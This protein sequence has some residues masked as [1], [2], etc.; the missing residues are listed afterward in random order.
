[1]KNSIVLSVKELHKLYP[2]RRSIIDLLRRKPRRWVHA[3]DGISIK[4]KQGE[5][6]ALVGE[7]GSG[8]TTTGLCLLGLVEPTEG[9]ILLQ[10]EDVGE[11]VHRGRS[12]E[13]RRI[14]QLIF[15]DPY[16]SLNPRQTVLKA[17]SEPLD[18]HR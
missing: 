7:S 12:K 8:K 13:L 10:G 11:L 5:I 4:L 15:Q 3:V 17:I 6:L 16:E 1:M 18:V 2:V 14:A 9:K